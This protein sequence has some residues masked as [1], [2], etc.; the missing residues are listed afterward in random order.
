MKEI[1]YPQRLKE[2]IV[3]KG[4]RSYIRTGSLFSPPS[5]PPEP[6]NCIPDEFTIK[7]IDIVDPNIKK[8]RMR[9]YLTV[10]GIPDD[11]WNFKPDNSEIGYI[12]CS[13]TR[14]STSKP[15][16]GR[17]VLF[18]YFNVNDFF[19]P[20]IHSFFYSTDTIVNGN[21]SKITLKGLTVNSTA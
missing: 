10:D 15:I 5:P 14:P 6:I 21:L 9:C 3:G 12:E 8:V 20:E 18:E 17:D 1:I 16:Y 4:D 7:A 19:G 2:V 11:Y 13:Y